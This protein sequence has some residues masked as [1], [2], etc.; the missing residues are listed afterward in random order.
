MNNTDFS[1][2]LAT[3]D[4]ALIQQLEKQ[5]EKK[6]NKRPDPRKADGKGKKGKGKDDDGLFRGKGKGKMATKG[7]VEKAQNQ[8]RDRAKERQDGK[9][10]YAHV[11]AEFENQE[12]VSLADSKYL[13]GDLEHT[14]L[15][16]GLDFSLLS[17]MRTELNKQVRHDEV[18]E[19]R[20]KAKNKKRTFETILAKQVWHAAVDTLHPHHTTFAKRM[21]N[22]GKAIS[23][24][25]RIR[26]AP[27]VFLPGRMA[28][29]FDTGLELGHQ[30]I[31]RIVFSAK[32][33]APA[34][35][36]S[37]KVA[38]ILPES[39]I[40]V[41]EAFQM[42][43][44][45]RKQRKLN[46]T[47]AATSHVAQ[48]VNVATRHHRAK[49]DADDI[50]GDAGSYADTVKEISQ[51]AKEKAA[52]AAKAAKIDPARSSYF[53]DAG[54]EK[55]KKAPEGQI[56]LNDMVVE[57]KPGDVTDRI[58]DEGKTSF[59]AAERFHGPKKGWVFKLG[60]QGLG[61]YLEK[62]ADT[63]AAGLA[64]SKDGRSSIRAAKK[65]NRENDEE[66][67]DDGYGE[68][69]PDSFAGGAMVTTVEE[70]DEEDDGKKKRKKGAEEEMDSSYGKKGGAEK[71]NAKKKKMSD[72]QYQN[73]QWQQIEGMIKNGKQKSIGE[74]DGTMN[75]R[76]A[77][78]PRHLSTP[79]F[80]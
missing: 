33:D 39:V 21:E 44:E 27:T 5:P 50:F 66:V 14:H 19:Q 45:N 12:E 68:C 38:A 56:D 25:Q 42:A 59:E 65:A 46:K 51:A 67:A 61:Y 32:E 47:P 29:E 31:P 3:N 43:L 22:M 37:K 17:K 63:S 6:K 73:K 13:G 11:A 1:R 69:F 80:F 23:L 60:T 36:N 79:A 49:D 78:V 18:K 9:E 8:Y 75:R 4:K 71:D 28:F 41:R 57:E 26:G 55:Y 30:D 16:K 24:G 2:L 54:A 53:D 74:L 58:A 52:R 35:D 77:P 72:E 48:K 20:E 76:N 10:E 7:D 15:V 62:E 34:V 40:R 70:G 64:A